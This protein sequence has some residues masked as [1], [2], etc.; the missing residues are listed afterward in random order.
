M[1]RPTDF[2]G[3]ERM[4]RGAAPKEHSRRKREIIEGDKR[5]QVK[6]PRGKISKDKKKLTD[7]RIWANV[8]EVG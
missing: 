3:E 4:C 8:R 2:A 7:F 1:S 5:Q 6:E